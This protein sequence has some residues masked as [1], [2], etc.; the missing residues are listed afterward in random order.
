MHITYINRI[1]LKRQHFNWNCIRIPNIIIRTVYF[2]D[3]GLWPINLYKYFVYDMFVWRSK[4]Q[5]KNFLC[6]TLTPRAPSS[7]RP[8]F[9]VLN[10]Q[11]L[12][13]GWIRLEL[14][15][16]AK[17]TICLDLAS[18]SVILYKMTANAVDV[19]WFCVYIYIQ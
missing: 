15:L 10:F 18:M 12:P 16:T 5:T 3:R 4:T 17:L 7:V 8:S 13:S 14:R 9:T 6:S 2:T 19:L 1:A 11:L